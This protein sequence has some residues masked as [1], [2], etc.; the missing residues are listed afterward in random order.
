[1]GTTVATTLP[2]QTAEAVLRSHVPLLQVNWAEPTRFALV[3]VALKMLPLLAAGRFPWQLYVPAVRGLPFQAFCDCDCD[4]CCD[5]AAQDAGGGGIN[6]N[7]AVTEATDVIVTVHAPVPL[8]PPPLQPANV[9]PAA[10][11]ALS[12]TELP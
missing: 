6:V 2:S 8:H 9:D 11:D 3:S 4:H 12:V 1:M 5:P 10:G 7:V